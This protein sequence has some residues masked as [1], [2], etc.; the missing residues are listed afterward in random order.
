MNQG[1]VALVADTAPV[2]GTLASAYNVTLANSGGVVYVAPVNIDVPPVGVVNQLN[3]APGVVDEAV[4]DVV[5]PGRIVCVG[6]VTVISGITIGF[7][8]TVTGVR[9]GDTQLP[10]ALSA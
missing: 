4:N 2:D 7:T 9:V 8:V 3:T 10:E 1:A 6:G 5:C